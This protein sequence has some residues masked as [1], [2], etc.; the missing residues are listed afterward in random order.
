MMGAFSRKK[1]Q[2]TIKMDQKVLYFFL[3]CS[4]K[5]SMVEWMY[6]LCKLS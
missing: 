1:I 4:Q 3:L 5:H 6:Y 2:I